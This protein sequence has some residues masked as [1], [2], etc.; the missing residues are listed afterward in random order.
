[1]PVK[2]YI[3]TLSILLPAW[4]NSVAEAGISKYQRLAKLVQ[5]AIEKGQLANGSKLP[6]HRYLADQLGVTPG[7]VSKAYQE[8]ERLGYLQ[9]RVGDGSYI[10][11]LPQ[12]RVGPEHFQT[13][14]WSDDGL[15]LRHNQHIPTHEV[16][17]LSQYWQQL[18]Q[19]PAYIQQLSR[20]SPEQGWPQHR[21]AGA[22]W[23]S[24]G[25]F[26]PQAEHI[27]C[28][29]GSQHALFSTL[30]ACLRAGEVI[31]TEHLSYPGLISAARILGIRVLGVAMDEQGILPD[32]LESLC[33][34][35]PIK[36]LYL[37]PSIQ[38][39]TTG[40]L[41]TQRRQQLAR[42]AQRYQL[43]LIEDETHAMLFDERPLPLS[44]YAPEHCILLSSLSKVACA[45]IRAGFIHAPA[46]LINK[47][48]QAIKAQSW[49]VNAFGLDIASQWIL[50]GKAS[51]LAQ[52]QLHALQQRKAALIP[53]LEGCQY[54]SHSHSPH[55][56][57]EVPEPWSA[58]EIAANLQQSGIRIATAE[59][60]AV[61]RQHQ[62][63]A[64]RVSISA[65]PD[66]L[67]AIA[68]AM[69]QLRTLLLN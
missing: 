31:A 21:Q 8:L 63:Q 22:R 13:Q 17:L 27:L 48:A 42:L 18:A 44:Y 24:L 40:V 36:A 47:L 19:Q 30:L 16:E 53:I 54:R 7:T 11:T 65:E 67:G 35:Y 9:A 34:Q 23:L 55:F 26:Q 25:S 41:D 28:C 64:I 3:D 60:F 10:R 14:T 5:Q 56:W 29:H 33:Q 50:S 49:M 37:T 57:L 61:G 68:Q 62:P 52:A 59:D 2:R 45:G 43:L 4:H 38:N 20:Y 15:D 39:P 1:M 69:Q 12:T 32:A 58:Q 6:P 51:Q 66:D 46:R